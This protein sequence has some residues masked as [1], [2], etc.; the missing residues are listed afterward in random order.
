M[1]YLSDK[2]NSVTGNAL[3]GINELKRKR[4]NKQLQ[5]QNSTDIEQ[6]NEGPQQVQDAQISPFYLSAAS[7]R[8]PKTMKYYPSQPF[9]GDSLSA[10]QPHPAP[11]IGFRVDY[12]NEKRAPTTFD[13]RPNDQSNQ[14]GQ[15]NIPQANNQLATASDQSLYEGDAWQR[16]WFQRVMLLTVVKLF[17]FIAKLYEDFHATKTYKQLGSS[18]HFLLSATTLFLPTIVFTIYRVCRY[19]QVELPSSRIQAISDGQHP[20]STP[21]VRAAKKLKDDQTVVEKEDELH[22][23]RAL[24]SSTGAPTDSNAPNQD[25]DGLVTA[26]QSPS[27]L[28]EFHDSK[29]QQGHISPEPPINIK[30]LNES[31]FKETVNIDKLGNIP[32]KETARLT[33]GASEQLLHGVLYVFWQLKRQVDVLSYLVERSCLWRKP[34]EDEKEELG[35]LQTGGDGLEWFQDFYAA[36]LAIVVQVYTLGSHW[37]HSTSGPVHSSTLKSTTSGLGATLMG[38][39]SSEQTISQAART[40]SNIIRQQEFNNKP[41]DGNDLLI[42]SQIFVSTF[43]VLSLLL[44]VRRRDDGPLTLGLS[45]LGWGSIFASRIIIIALAFV[46]VGWKI[47]LPLVLGHVLGITG[48]IYKIAIDSHNDKPSESE[49][50]K[51]DNPTGDNTVE[52]ESSGEAI[53]TKPSATP[54]E[55]ETSK[56]SP[57]EHVVLLAQILSL[58]AI[59]SLFYW[60][61][62]FNL[63]LHCRPFKYLVLILT[64]NFILVPAIWLTISSTATPGQWYLL[65]AV[66]GFSIVGFI[67]VSLYVSCKPNLTEYF[68]RADEQFNQAERSGIYFEFCSR[69]FKM[70]DLSKSSFKRLMVQT[71]QL[72]EIAQ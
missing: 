59:P 47:M 34:R 8:S 35:R 54:G 7:S 38:S 26:R 37:S 63:K 5:K 3:S 28:E 49:E 11:P 1:D 2:L 24:M 23:R 44:A 45:M 41:V 65:G 32:D 67:F 70:P 30:T 6:V 56:W 61:I 4:N 10:A 31:N 36:F 52:L 9:G 50:Y 51:W 69:V 64:E 13:E 60:P 40:L 18:G 29:S 39:E 68:A 33:I 55:S 17:T 25:D 58:F 71:E 19:L 43:V 14:V 46:H 72:E 15:P 57:I 22:L 20:I 21:V 48:W 42:T 16:L 27:A 53:S 12:S 66:G 62:M